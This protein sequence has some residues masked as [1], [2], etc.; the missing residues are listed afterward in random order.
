MVSVHNLPSVSGKMNTNGDTVWTRNYA[1]INGEELYACGQTFD[2]GYFI[3]GTILANALYDYIL[4]KTDSNGVPQWSKVYA[5]P[6]NESCYT[7]IQTSDSGFVL[8]GY[9]QTS[10]QSVDINVTN[11]SKSGTNSFCVI[12]LKE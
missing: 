11:T 10:M 2:G 3:A 5:S 12:F 4:I 9:S 7:A 1:G 6:L 8:A